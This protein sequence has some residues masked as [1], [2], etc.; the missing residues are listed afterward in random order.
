MSDLLI[1][2]MEI[3]F[4]NYP[5]ANS[6][7]AMIF[8]QWL[9]LKEQEFLILENDGL[10]LKLWFD[11]KT[12]WWASQ[13]NEDEITKWTNVMARKIYADVTINN[14]NQTF[15]QFISTRDYSK[16]LEPRDDELQKEYELLGKR[17]QEF[18]I[19][20]LNR[21]IAYVRAYKGQYWLQEYPYDR[22]Y[23]AK[24]SSKARINNGEWFV[25]QP[26]NV[27]H[28]NV[29]LDKNHERYLNKNDWNLSKEFVSSSKKTDLHWHLLAGAE[30]LASINNKRAALTEAVTALEVAVNFFASNPNAVSVLG[31]HLSSRVDIKRLEKQVEHMGLSGTVNYLFP[32]LF[33]EE[34]VP[35]SVLTVCQ[36]ALAVRGNVVHNGQREIDDKKLYTLINGIRQLCEI[37]EKFTENPSN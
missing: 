35:L 22:D 6:D 18:A 26:S 7:S 9:P 21:L 19:Y 30:A 12:T 28:F 31:D 37:L 8:H 14:L 20:H 24:F 10:R 13:P 27:H 36:E 4:L 23:S 25:W 29:I 1:I 16:K 11:V 17:V 34:Q 32:V 2:R 5:D 33:S 15:L 3:P